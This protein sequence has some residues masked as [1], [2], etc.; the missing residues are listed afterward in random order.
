MTDYER[1]IL[2]HNQN[3]TNALRARNHL[4]SKQRVIIASNVTFMFHLSLE[5]SLE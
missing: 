2:T 5:I 1:H 4:V 3:C